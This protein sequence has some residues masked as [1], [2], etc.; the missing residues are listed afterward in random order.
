MNSPEWIVSAYNAVPSTG[1]D[2]GTHARFLDGI[3]ALPGVGGLELP[4]PG[5][6]DPHTESWFRRAGSGLSCTLTTIPDTM[7][8]VQHDPAFGL[9]STDEWRRR[10]AVTRLV[11]VAETVRRL[12]DLTARQAVLAVTVYSAP[13]LRTGYGSGSALAASLREIAEWEWDGARLLLEHCDAPIRNRPAVKGFLPLGSEL[14]AITE[15][16]AH[17][18]IPIGLL[19][20]W[21]RS[22]LEQR[23]A[24][25]GI[26]HVLRARAAGVLA[27][28]TFSGCA[29]VAT[30]H[31]AGWD[32]CHLPPAPVCPE[33]LLTPD[34]IAATLRAAGPGPILHGLKV[35]APRH[36]S[37]A[38]RLATVT[39]S[40]NA[41]HSAFAA[42]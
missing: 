19:V 17:T 11:R 29:P 23:S 42:A 32:D 8:R 27:G 35:S 10:T 4:F 41:L 2:H 38:V 33:S 22:A 9:A 21:G 6:L 40:L 13:R 15:A 14:A 36:A 28:L 26:G 24:A 31:G 12:N 39:R 37:P 7:A 1:W 16:N 25:G 34:W 3:A 5:R 18:P 30:A 20:N